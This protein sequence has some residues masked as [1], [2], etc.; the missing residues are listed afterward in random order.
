[1]SLFGFIG[2]ILGGGSEKKAA[3]KA[4]RAQV[5]AMDK[6]IAE[7]RRQYDTTRE[8]YAPYRETGYEGLAGLG[9]LV[10]TN[11]NEAQGTAIEALKSSPFYQALLRN[12]EEALLQNASATGGIRGG[13]TQRGLA[14]FGADTLAST[15]DR[16]ISALGGLAGM[17]LG[18]T[19]SLAG[20]GQQTANNVSGL[21][22]GQGDARASSALA[23][24]GINSRMWQSAGSFLDQAVAAF[25]PGGGGMAS[26]FGGAG[27]I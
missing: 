4:M 2:G 25:M 3:K 21:L 22:K 16:Q 19:N 18:A 7:Q 24:G 13:N 26:V 23:I 6:A 9:D 5:E 10:G 12:G 14:D 15:I 11:G 17:G 1:M 8:D 20:F 27:G